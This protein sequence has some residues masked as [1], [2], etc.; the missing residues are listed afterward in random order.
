MQDHLVAP[1]FVFQVLCL[2]LWS[3]D[4][5]WYY[6]VFTLLMLMFF[7]G[8]MCRQRQASLT[9]LRNMRRPPVRIYVFRAGAWLAVSSDSLVPGDL[10]SL[11][12]DMSRRSRGMCSNE[13]SLLKSADER[14]YCSLTGG[15]AAG[16][17][18]EESANVVPCDALLLRGSCVVNEAM[19]TGESVPQMKE[20]LRTRSSG[21]TSASTA[22]NSTATA[23]EDFVDLGSDSH[24]DAQ[25]KRHMVFSGTSLLLHTERVDADLGVPS[26]SS[27]AP[28]LSAPDGGCVAV[29]I[30]TGFGTSQVT[31]HFTH[32]Y[33][34][35][36]NFNTNDN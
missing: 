13:F 36:F 9:M 16:G 10:I 31:Q 14:L 29:V 34:F 12:A 24:V 32:A 19:L 1:F 23:S 33:I 2:F 28:V 21:G 4:D 7:E 18:G 11:T 26:A 27:Q 8:M 25:W 17:G 30:R 3:L 20:T 35:A 6:S 15:K 22:T 5:Y